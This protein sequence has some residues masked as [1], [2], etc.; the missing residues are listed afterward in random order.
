MRGKTVS[1]DEIQRVLYGKP[2]EHEVKR[3]KIFVSRHLL[4]RPGDSTLLQI[5]QIM[6]DA[7][8]WYG[9]RGRHD[10]VSQ[11]LEDVRKI[12]P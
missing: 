2:S 7:G 12:L 8:L 3:V 5:K 1:K 11:T 9:K 10:T 6:I 4:T